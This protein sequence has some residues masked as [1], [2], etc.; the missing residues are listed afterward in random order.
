VSPLVS[1][2]GEGLSRFAN[3]R[4]RQRDRDRETERDG[5]RETERGVAARVLPRRG[6]LPLCD[7]HKHRE[8]D[9]DRDRDRETET[10]QKKLLFMLTN[11]P[12]VTQTTFKFPVYIGPDSNDNK[13]PKSQ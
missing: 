11:S 8:R 6:T 13:R 3:V 10:E 12:I 1:Y 2:R 4:E 5:D 7:P 9:R